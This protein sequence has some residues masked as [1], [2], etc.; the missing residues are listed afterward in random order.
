MCDIYL[1]PDKHSKIMNRNHDPMQISSHRNVITNEKN[2]GR[3]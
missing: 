1:A 2:L 3:C